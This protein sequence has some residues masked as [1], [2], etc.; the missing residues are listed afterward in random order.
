V[1]YTR[2]FN[3]D[4]FES[5]VPYDPKTD[6]KYFLQKIER[7]FLTHFLTQ[8]RMMFD[9][10]LLPTLEPCLEKVDRSRKCRCGVRIALV[11]VDNSPARWLE[12]IDDCTV[13]LFAAEHN[14]ETR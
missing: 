8:R 13:D 12:V 11:Q 6:E 9:C 10:G 5:R 4:E 3:A 7:P 2:K 1:K 14:C